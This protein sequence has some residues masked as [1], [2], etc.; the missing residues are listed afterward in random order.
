MEI[1]DESLSLDMGIEAASISHSSNNK[2]AKEYSIR[3]GRVVVVIVNLKSITF[4]NETESFEEMRF[5]HY[6]KLKQRKIIKAK[7]LLNQSNNDNIYPANG[8]GTKTKKYHRTTKFISTGSYSTYREEQCNL[9]SIVAI[10]D[11]ENYSQ[12]ELRYF[13]YRNGCKFPP[14][15]LVNNELSSNKIESN[16]S[17]AK[18]EEK[19]KVEDLVA[20][21]PI[22][23]ESIIEVRILFQIKQF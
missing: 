18:K 23:L 14:K 15:P 10:E 9:I 4:E 1:T 21:C 22:C 12:E 11:Y 20:S 13:D 5:G 8:D 16:K 7:R 6:L 3:N 19:P 17:S 2:L